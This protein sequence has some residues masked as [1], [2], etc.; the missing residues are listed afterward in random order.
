MH[1]KHVFGIVYHVC[2][3]VV[4]LLTL[5][6]WA[7]GSFLVFRVHSM[8]ICPTWGNMGKRAL[9]I[10]LLLIIIM[11]LM[12][13]CLRVTGIAVYEQNLNSDVLLMFTFKPSLHVS[14]QR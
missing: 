12:N 10:Q 11:F 2:H 4:R 13:F 1:G 8:K 9:Q 7:G 14:Y 6:W 3:G 5:A